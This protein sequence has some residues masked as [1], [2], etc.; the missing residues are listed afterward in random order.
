MH[1]RSQ[2]RTAARIRHIGAVGLWPIVRVPHVGRAGRGPARARGTSNVRWIVLD[3]AVHS[4]TRVN[5]EAERRV[6]MCESV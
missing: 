4:W 1:G 3:T 5:Y 2:R 6:R